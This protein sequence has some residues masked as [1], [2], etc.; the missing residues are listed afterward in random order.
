MLRD[1][2]VET[3]KLNQAINKTHNRSVSE[4][5]EEIIIVIKKS[6]TN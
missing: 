2:I 4:L 3:P 6:R 1:I 5:K